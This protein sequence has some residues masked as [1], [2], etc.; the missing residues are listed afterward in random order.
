MYNIEYIHLPVPVYVYIL[1]RLCV[2]S[3]IHVHVHVYTCIHEKATFMTLQELEKRMEL[4]QRY[5]VMHI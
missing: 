5:I 2:R 3:Y 1:L 4:R